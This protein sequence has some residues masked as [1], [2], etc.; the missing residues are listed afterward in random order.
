MTTRRLVV[1][2]I[3]TNFNKG[4]WIR[5][6]VESFLAQEVDFNY[7]IILVDDASTD[8]SREIIKEY[9]EKYPD[10]IRA[11]YN[12]KNLGIT[13]TWIKACKEA[14]GKYIARCDGDDYWTD[15]HKL[16][17]Q[18]DTLEASKNSQ[19]SNTDFD[20]ILSDRTVTNTS[21]FERGI[22]KRPYSY[23]DLI[24][25]K[26]FTMSSTWLIEADLI[27]D[28]NGIIDTN[29]VDD[30]F[31]IQ[32]ELFHRTKLSYLPQST[33][34][35]RTNYESDSKP[36]DLQ[37]KKLR[38]ERLLKTQ[39][40]YIE[41]YQDVDFGE[42]IKLS[43]REN[44]DIEAI[45]AETSNELKR[46]NEIIKGQEDIIK[47]QEHIIGERDDQIHALKREVTERE[48]LLRSIT[49]T[50]FYKIKRLTE[51]PVKV[52]RTI[53][54]DG[55]VATS[56]KI[57][58]MTVLKNK[59]TRKLAR[60][61]LG[62]R[63]GG[64]RNFFEHHYPTQTQIT[65]M[66]SE[67]F[68]INPRI[69]IIMPTYNT[70]ERFLREAIQ[71]VQQQ[72]Y[73][74]WELVIV[75]DA[76]PDAKVRRVIDEYAAVEPRIIKKYLKKNH[77]IAAA[78]NEGIKIATGEFISLFDHDDLLWPNA[79]YEIVK[80][81][82]ENPNLDFIYTDED[83]VDQ[84]TH[85][86]FDPFFKPDWNPDFLRSAN[87]ITHFTTIRKEILNEYGYEDGSY[88]GAQDWELFLRI[89]RNIDATRICHIPKIVYSWRSH[90]LST[91][92]SGG[93]KPYVVKAQERAVRDDTV[94]RGYENI[95]LERNNNDYIQV[96]Y[97]LQG[98]PL[99]S[100]LILAND[101]TKTQE[102]VTSLY[103]YTAYRNFEVVVLDM[104]SSNDT[105]TTHDLQKVLHNNHN[106]TV[107]TPP[108]SISGTIDQYKYAA[109]QAKG[110]LIVCMAQGVK[111]VTEDWIAQM[112]G[113]AQR[114]DVGV[115]GPR[116][117]FSNG[118]VNHT[119][120]RPIFGDSRLSVMSLLGGLKPDQHKT[121]VQTLMLQATH[122][123]PIV[124]PVF[125]MTKS[126]IFLQKDS[127]GDDEPAILAQVRLQFQLWSNR[128]YNTYI[129]SVEVVYDGPLEDQF[130]LDDVPDGF[131]NWLHGDSTEQE[132]YNSN[133][134]AEKADYSL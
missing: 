61:L 54:D 27:R 28:I 133:L 19:W 23:E 13:K 26:G 130:S 12:D 126:S 55:L 11:L 104:R 108:N 40:E 88:N 16:Q 17:M 79:L 132:I 93:A 66:K 64:Y 85:R 73:E 34:V 106:L 56:K 33:T 98:R 46:S 35:Y 107:Y 111:I 1:S 45:L 69:S 74:N 51:L 71:S 70:S 8:I 95:S 76:S 113:Y 44:A 31:N 65:A 123:Q 114:V 78:T 39:L 14:K 60:K 10:L 131:I 100:V 75:D 59:K 116:V 37:K 109:K 6:A 92:D 5:D 119:G 68:V 83:K 52:S 4:E 129:P 122:N 84:N 67:V 115:V 36:A 41:K 110:E 81:L 90:A 128:H 42:M 48:Q 103:Q 82:N 22:I 77:H 102:S 53:V 62:K 21:A 57:A 112:A 97:S 117:I 134:D 91:A 49:S 121:L 38:S 47:G 89:T 50:R 86:H 25:T 87:Y 124:S 118:E 20:I 72:A 125:N 43:L 127:Q 30:T 18:V 58:K 3:C 99:V 94:A 2:I 9:E 7:E 101:L 29:A 105:G 15:S 80:A 24:V 32:I 96:R 63:D 120:L